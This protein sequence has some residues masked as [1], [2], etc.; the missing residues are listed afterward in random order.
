MLR[1][2]ENF[3]EDTEI[4]W[5]NRRCTPWSFCNSWKYE[6]DAAVSTNYRRGHWK[7]WRLWCNGFENGHMHNNSENPNYIW[8]VLRIS[9]FFEAVSRGTV[10]RLSQILS[11]LGCFESS[12]CSS[13]ESVLLGIAAQTCYVQGMKQLSWAVHRRFYK[14]QLKSKEQTML[15]TSNNRL[16]FWWEKI[17]EIN[18]LNNSFMLFEAY[19]G[20]S[21]TFGW[22]CIA[23]SIVSSIL[24]CSFSWVVPWSYPYPYR[25]LSYNE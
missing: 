20:Y 11:I 25:V 17:R 13:W 22:C 6:L 19:H 10:N 4:D 3:L 2:P 14:E 1:R 23:E 12:K 24:I 18:E 8:I 15:V 16:P 5:G 21:A 9:G 7:H